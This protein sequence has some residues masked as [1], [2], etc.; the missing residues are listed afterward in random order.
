MVC[1]ASSRSGMFV[2]NSRKIALLD[3]EMQSRHQGGL[4]WA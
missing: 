1:Y 3:A 4:W 2:C